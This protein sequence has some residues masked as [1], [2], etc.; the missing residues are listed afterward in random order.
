L[1]SCGF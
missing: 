1:E